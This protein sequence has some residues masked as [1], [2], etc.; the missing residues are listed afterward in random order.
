[1]NA[2][3]DFKRAFAGA[4]LIAFGLLFALCCYGMFEDLEGLWKTG[5]PHISSG[6]G[7][8]SA[9]LR[10]LDEW[11]NGWIT[12]PCYGLFAGYCLYVVWSMSH[13]FVSPE[14]AVSIK[15]DVVHF[16]KGLYSGDAVKIFDIITID[17]SFDPENPASREDHWLWGDGLER[18]TIAFKTP[19][20]KTKR[21]VL[22]ARR[23]RGGCDSLVE[24]AKELRARVKSSV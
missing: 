8:R 14:C 16:N 6:S 21:V 23:V 11:S 17:L 2:K 18:L 22:S 12:L 5:T 9:W 24:F 1:M 3:L 20:G 19:Y 13:L 4:S 7:G 15:N 10:D